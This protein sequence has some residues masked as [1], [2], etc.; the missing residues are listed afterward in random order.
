MSSRT[1]A[2]VLALGEQ[3]ASALEG[4]LWSAEL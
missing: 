1:D 3:Q 4:R 2:V